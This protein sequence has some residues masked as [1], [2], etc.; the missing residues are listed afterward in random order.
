MSGLVEPL[1]G[2][3]RI[4]SVAPWKSSTNLHKNVR[5]G[6]DSVFTQ[7]VKAWHLVRRSI[8]RGHDLE[9][10]LRCAILLLVYFGGSTLG[11][12][13]KQFYY[14]AVPEG[15][16]LPRTPWLFALYDTEN[17]SSETLYF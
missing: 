7:P 6:A 16:V 10:P 9:F 12:F 5:R 14:C 15:V 13:R 3:R 17:S 8:L 2:M 11:L 4:S 1:G